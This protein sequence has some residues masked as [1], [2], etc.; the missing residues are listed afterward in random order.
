MRATTVLLIAVLAFAAD[1]CST[2]ADALTSS[3]D[4]APKKKK[5]K[6]PS[7][8]DDELPPST[9]PVCQ[10]ECCRGAPKTGCARVWH[11]DQLPFDPNKSE[12]FEEKQAKVKL[13]PKLIQKG[14]KRTDIIGHTWTMCCP[15]AD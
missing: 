3:N 8:D 15:T 2:I 10:N 12:S 5:K 1:G 6:K 11:C 9:G 7:S 13:T 4:D 14:C